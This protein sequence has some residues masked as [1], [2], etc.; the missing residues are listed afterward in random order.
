MQGERFE[1]ERLAM[2]GEFLEDGV[3]SLDPF[4]VLLQLVLGLGLVE[5]GMETC[6]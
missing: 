3:G 5:V 1:C 2:V 6:Q 4:F